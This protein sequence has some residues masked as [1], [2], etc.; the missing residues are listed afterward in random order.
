ML[1]RLRRE[2]ILIWKNNIRTIGLA[3]MTRLHFLIINGIFSNF[4]LIFSEKPIPSMDRES[5]LSRFPNFT[6]DEVEYNETLEDL[7][8]R[9]YIK[10]LM[11][12]GEACLRCCGGSHFTEIFMQCRAELQ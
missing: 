7:K 11:T 1:V 12:I 6:L 5:N 3:P 9:E 4:L 2:P 10:T 8:L